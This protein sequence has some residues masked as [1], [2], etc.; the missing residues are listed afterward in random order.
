MTLMAGVDIGN[1]TTEVVIADTTTVPPEP[2][3]WDRVPTRGAKGSPE[4]ARRAARLVQRLARRS[5]FTPE[6]VAMTPQQPVLTGVHALPRVQRAP[7]RLVILDDHPTTPA[8]NGVACGRPVA[9]GAEPPRGIAV[10]LVASDP[11]SY[12]ETADTIRRWRTSGIDVRGALLVGDE[13]RLVHARVGSDLVIVDRVNADLALRCELIALEVNDFVVGALADPLYLLAHLELLQNE[14]P[15]ATIVA[16]A[17]RESRCAVVGRLPV[18]VD[19]DLHQAG[20]LTFTDGSVVNLREARD[21]LAT[22]PAGSTAHLVFANGTQQ[23]VFDAWVVDIQ[24]LGSPAAL[25]RAAIAPELAVSTL[26][27]TGDATVA[28]LAFR[29]VNPLPIMIVGNEARAAAVGART[30]PGCAK[31]TVVIDLGGGTIDII[32]DGSVTGAGSGDLLSACI[33]ALAGISLGAAEWVKQGPAFRIETPS[34]ASS[35][36]LSQDFLPTRV[37]GSLVGWLAVNGPA[38]PLPFSRALTLG[39][40]RLLRLAAKRAVIEDNVRRISGGLQFDSRTAVA[41]GGPVGDREI[42]ACLSSALPALAIG[43]G[44][45]AGILGHRF[46]VAYGLVLLANQETQRT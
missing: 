10:I 14:I 36:T 32:T 26:A 31:D 17:V 44:N 22:R 13:A 33:G 18:A 5:G 12:R 16:A 4:A 28:D 20:S 43:R 19:N 38:G 29:E 9:Q 46:A 42:L 37:P 39:D 15:D 23:D 40:W 11:L 1:S 3:A 21:G 30:T 6:L 7:G 41:V 45:I 27:T 24:S 35:E 8:G 25:R 2:C 34:I